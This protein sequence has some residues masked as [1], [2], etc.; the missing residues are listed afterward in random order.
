VADRCVALL[1]DGKLSMLPGGVDEYLERRAAGAALSARAASAATAPAPVAERPA[2]SSNGLSAKELRELQKEL[3]R[4]ERQIDKLGER[5]AK[6][7]DQMAEAASDFER[8]GKL[9]AELREI[10]LQKES[11]ELEWMTLAEGLDS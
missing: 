7:H 8:L 2:A 10:G 6:L 11:A 9:D 1:G 3:N 4:L 5:E